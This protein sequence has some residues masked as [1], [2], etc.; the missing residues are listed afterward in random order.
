MKKMMKA[1]RIF[2]VNDIRIVEVPVPELGSHD[3]LCRVVKVGVCGTDY[4]I[5]TG[6]L[7]FIKTGAIKFPMTP[8]HEWSG[9]VEKSGSAVENF[10]T[11]DRVVGD[12]MVSCGVCYDCLVGAYS[13][14][15][16]GRAVGTIYTWDGAYAEYI[17]MPDR[18]LFH[19][20]DPVSFDN[21]AMVEP[22]ATALYSVTRANVKIADTVL[23]H[24]TGPIGIMAAKLAK[25]CGAVKVIITGR[26]EF[27]LQKALALGADFAINTT[28]ENLAENV[29]EYAGPGGV[30]K[31]IEASGSTQL[32][33]ESLGLVKPGG[34]ISIV[35]FYEKELERFD[36]DK[37]VMSD[38]T[39]RAVPGSLG[40]Y[41]PIL[42]LMASG[43]IDFTPLITGR[44]PFG[45]V[46]Q[47][48]QDMGTKNDTR[49]KIM[50]EMT[51]T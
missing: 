21:G 41:G 4:S 8:G 31:V 35:A 3:V 25:L 42:K 30:D 14:C 17:M 46:E 2:G 39:I 10:K 26:K 23:V 37:F 6:T 7:S 48:L 1:A 5:Y 22:A 11:G 16:K 51:E 20:P 34:I 43:T 13:H 47:A 29:R 33:T 15:K 32:F 28:R 9:I 50:L 27:K 38:L 36:L 49:I 12:T 19:L 24:G 44:Y 45:E 40:M 18:H